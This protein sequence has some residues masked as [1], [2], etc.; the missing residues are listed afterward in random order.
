MAK[1][2]YGFGTL[3]F[4]VSLMALPLAGCGNEPE[5]PSAPNPE[6]SST[7]AGYAIVDLGALTPT[8]R[9][10]AFAINDNGLV[11]GSS[12]DSAGLSLFPLAWSAAGTMRLLPLLPGAMAGEAKGVNNAGVIV[13]YN[14][15]GGSRRAT[16]W[17]RVSSA[18]QD[19]GT[20]GGVTA[21]AYDINNKGMIVGM[22]TPTGGWWRAFAWTRAGGMIDLG[23]LGGGAT[24]YSFA[25]A[26]NDA[27]AVAG[28]STTNS[29][30]HAFYWSPST[31]M[32][33]LGT[34]G[35]M[36]SYALG[37]NDKGMVVGYSRDAS[38]SLHAFKWTLAGGMVDLGAVLPGFVADFAN[39]VNAHGRIVGRAGAV[40]WY[41]AGGTIVPM[42]GLSGGT[43]LALA[44][45]KC[46]VI[47]GTSQPPGQ[48]QY[49]HA[50]KWTKPC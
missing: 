17:S 4:V 21:D 31:G 30:I 14:T 26:V 32:I 49:T 22:S 5:V 47:A 48:G 18:P 11:A 37:I 28:Y 25:T 1:V 40:A 2:A 43:S 13:G 45:N 12:T 15:V 24:G 3:C 46:G 38:Q 27:G 23:I 39:G 29:W 7:N 9:S 19:I 42:T 10:W 41:T 8:S 35:G 6:L 34:L 16:R 20:L 33:D 36:D 50:V 44:I